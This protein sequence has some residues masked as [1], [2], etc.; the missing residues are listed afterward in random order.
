MGLVYFNGK[1][2]HAR[3][4]ISQGNSETHSTRKDWLKKIRP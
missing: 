1:A 4:K 2:F 3:Q